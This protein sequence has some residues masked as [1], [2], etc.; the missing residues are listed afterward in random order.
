MKIKFQ[1]QT[2][3]S[4]TSTR[5]V[6]VILLSAPDHTLRCYHET[7]LRPTRISPSVVIYISW[8]P[9]S[10]YYLSSQRLNNWDIYAHTNNIC[11]FPMQTTTIRASA[12]II[13]YET[14][15]YLH[16][17]VRLPSYKESWVKLCSVHFKLSAPFLKVNV[18][19]YLF[20]SECVHE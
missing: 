3:W 9:V 1:D 7:K 11:V 4:V 2:P 13:E 5:Y 14:R 6:F 17:L 8:F 12:H 18:F 15:G 19:E 10:P 16:P 20:W